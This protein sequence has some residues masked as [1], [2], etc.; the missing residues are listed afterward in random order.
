MSDFRPQALF[1][2]VGGTI[3]DWKESIVNSIDGVI[4]E[5]LSADEVNRFAD[6]WR[7]G[8]FKQRSLVADGH[9]PWMNS[10]QIHLE[11]LTSLE[12]DFAF[13]DVLDDKRKFVEAVW[14]NLEPFKGATEALIRFI[15][16][17]F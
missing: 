3:F 5:K 12:H 8:M 9:V 13:I 2:D 6:R 17:W 16:R 7:A 11:A 14:H 4:T 1:F 15:Q 10:D